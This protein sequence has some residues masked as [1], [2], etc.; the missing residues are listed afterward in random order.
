M[1][2]N[3]EIQMATGTKGH[4]YVCGAELG[5]TAMK[6][7]IHKTHDDP[8]GAQ[9][10]S[11][12]KI[13]GAYAK[14]YW[15]YIDIPVTATLSAVDAF[16]REIWLECCGHLSA[17]YG[18]GRMEVNPRR[19]LR[20]FPIGDKLRHE[21]DFGAT[22]ETLITIVGET[23]RKT[24]R[25]AVRLLARNIPP[26]FPCPVCGKP[27]TWLCTECIYD[28]GS[29]FLCDECGEAH[30]H[31]D[32]LLPVVNSPRMGTCGYEGEMDHFTFYPQKIVGKT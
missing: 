5:K 14:D 15:L 30:E 21:Y 13:E 28:E 10:C 23:V 2:G 12:L 3:G 20:E 16:L 4:C 22:T 8:H 31:E 27:A 18:Y 29:P 24:Q 9:K 17:F 32:M 11:L 7:H 26:V 6:N 1:I 25:D 19:K